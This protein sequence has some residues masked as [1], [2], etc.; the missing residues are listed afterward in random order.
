M[1]GRQSK[2][3]TYFAKLVSAAGALFLLQPNAAH[4]LLL[5]DGIYSLLSFAAEDRSSRDSRITRPFHVVT[6]YKRL[7]LLHMIQL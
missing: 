6:C 2:V 3:N 4:A 7:A 1:E 5:R